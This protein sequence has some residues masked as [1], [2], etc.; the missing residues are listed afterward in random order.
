M[1]TSL[2][3]NGKLNKLPQNQ[4]THKHQIINTLPLHNN[5]ISTLTCS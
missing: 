3:L 2:N 5:T 1:F 4:K